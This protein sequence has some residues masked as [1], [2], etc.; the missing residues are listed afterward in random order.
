MS[1]G[2][3][4]SGSS[5][6]ARARG[7]CAAGAALVLLGSAI[8][9]PLSMASALTGTGSGS[10]SVLS[11]AQ[12]LDPESFSEALVD[13]TVSV[14]SPTAPGRS[15]RAALYSLQQFMFTGSVAWGGYRFTYYSQQVLPGPGLRI[16]GRHV[17]SDGYVS[18]GDGFIVLAGSAP[19][20]SVFETPF[21]YQGKIYD[22]GTFGNHLDV[23]IR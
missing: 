13:T 14:A 17:N 7:A 16:P 6:W 12:R 18:D 1:A 8:T 5:R 11:G 10:A 9:A 22:R 19:K 21:G 20:G 23:Y 2:P 15:E 3:V 4:R